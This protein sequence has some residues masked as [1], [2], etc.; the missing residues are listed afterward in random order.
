MALIHVWAWSPGLHITHDV[1]YIQLV[2]ACSRAQREFQAIVAI[3]T[4]VLHDAN[5]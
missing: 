5:K 2:N 4:V 1:Y 3:K